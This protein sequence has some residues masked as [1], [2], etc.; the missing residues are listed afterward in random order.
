MDHTLQTTELYFWTAESE[1]HPPSHR[2]ERLPAR[3]R[4]PVHGASVRCGFPAPAAAAL[5]HDGSDVTAEG[6]VARRDGR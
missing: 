3:A 1:N 2:P 6:D 4:R 5:E